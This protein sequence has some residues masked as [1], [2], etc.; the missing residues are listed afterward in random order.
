MLDA[1]LLIIRLVIGFIMM[2]HA[3]KKLF[4]WFGGEGISGTAEF[5]GAI[6]L[7]PARVMAVCGG[8]IELIGG[9]L[10]GAGLWT[11][12]AVILLII[13]MVVAIAKVH[14]GKGLW[15]L[16]GGFEY[17]LVMLGSLIGVALAGAGAYSLDT[18]I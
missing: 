14:A 8:L 3:C 9:F 16:N 10:F 15:N 1:G 17:N 12:F 2:G 13:P 4:G 7:R 11:V 5:F 6:G 18:L